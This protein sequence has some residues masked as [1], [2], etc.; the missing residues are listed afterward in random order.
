MNRRL[1][2][3]K[4]LSKRHYYDVTKG[5]IERCAWRLPFSAD[6]LIIAYLTRSLT[7]ILIEQNVG[8]ILIINVKMFWSSLI[9]FLFIEHRSSNLKK[10]TVLARNF[11]AISNFIWEVHNQKKQAER[12]QNFKNSNHYPFGTVW[13]TNIFLVGFQFLRLLQVLRFHRGR[14]DESPNFRIQSNT[15]ICWRK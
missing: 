6:E 14:F 3:R 11:P 5:E 2:R 10:E 4:P 15:Q 9:W 12:K 1:E 7:H 8:F 13:E